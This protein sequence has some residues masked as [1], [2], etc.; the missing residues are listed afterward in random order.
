MVEISM[1]YEVIFVLA[2]FHLNKKRVN[3]F[4]FTLFFIL[5]KAYYAF[6]S[7]PYWLSPFVPSVTAKIKL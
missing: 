7:G 2:S 3:R 5:V 1:K 6:G 4:R